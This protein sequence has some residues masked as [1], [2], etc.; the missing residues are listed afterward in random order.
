M[1]ILHSGRVGSI[2]TR[3]P[4]PESAHFTPTKAEL[5]HQGREKSMSN[6]VLTQLSGCLGIAPPDIEERSVGLVSFAGKKLF[7]KFRR[8]LPAKPACFGACYCVKRK[9]TAE[10]HTRQ[11][12]R[13]LDI[14][15][16]T[17]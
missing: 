2:P 9:G 13:G 7:D 10:D 6:K 4:I 14:S 1:T 12:K 11:G 16:T 15:S 5:N 3:P 8:L 17:T